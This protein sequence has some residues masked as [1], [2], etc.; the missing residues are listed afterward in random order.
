M[1]HYYIWRK[2]VL[3]IVNQ[4]ATALRSG[5]YSQGYNRMKSA[6]GY[7]CLGVP[8]VINGLSCS[9]DWE[10]HVMTYLPDPGRFHMGSNN[11]GIIYRKHG[12]EYNTCLASINDCQIDFKTI[13]DIIEECWP[14]ISVI[15]IV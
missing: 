4:W 10:G 8:H 15:K 2:E 3:D 13:S 1:F 5:R 12:V 7:C 6:R 11:G 9:K 14:V